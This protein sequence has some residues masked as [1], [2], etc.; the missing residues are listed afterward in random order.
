MNAIAILSIAVLGASAY[1]YG[2][3]LDT[4]K[5]DVYI[6]A[7]RVGHLLSESWRGLQGSETYDPATLLGA[8]LTITPSQGPAAPEGF[9]P[10][11]SYGIT[12]DNVAYNATLSWKDVSSG[13]RA[14]HVA[15]T[16]A[17][18][19][20]NQNESNP[21]GGSLAFTTYVLN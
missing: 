12:L 9:T 6:A 20:Q 21:V 13:L 8:G 16:W 15:L 7:T 11:G 4:R 18:G 5:A 3:T 14:L 2:A 17:L 1:R 10:L 19:N